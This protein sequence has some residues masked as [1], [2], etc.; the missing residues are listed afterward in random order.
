LHEC[1]DLETDIIEK[2]QLIEFFDNPSKVKHIKERII[3]NTNRCFG[4]RLS[5]EVFE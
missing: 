2:E 1:N 3:G 5:Y 4:A